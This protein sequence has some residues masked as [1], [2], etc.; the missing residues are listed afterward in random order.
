MNVID[1]LSE[2]RKATILVRVL[3]VELLAETTITFR[4]NESSKPTSSFFDVLMIDN[5]YFLTFFTIW[6][7]P[8][9][10]DKRQSQIGSGLLDSFVREVSK[11]NTFISNEMVVFRI[12]KRKVRN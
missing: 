9:L 4:F 8:S 10:G 2:E 6:S 1:H 5:F 3:K 12:I 11:F 7:I